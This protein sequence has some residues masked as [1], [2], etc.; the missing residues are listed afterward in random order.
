MDQVADKVDVLILGGGVAGTSLA[1]TLYEANR[2]FLLIDDGSI[3]S[4]SR[5]AAGLVTPITGKRLNETY[6]WSTAF[7]RSDA[8][9]RQVEERL[10]ET[11]W[12]RS[13]SVRMIDDTQS[14]EQIQERLKQFSEV[15]TTWLD[16]T[17]FDSTLVN[18]PRG[19]FM[20]QASRLDTKRYLEKSHR[21]FSVYGMYYRSWVDLDEDIFL[22]PNNVYFRPS[23]VSADYA[24]C[25]RG[26]ADQSHRLFNNARFNPVQGDILRI[27]LEQP[28]DNTTLHCNWW[29][30]PTQAEKTVGCLDL[31]RRPKV[32]DWLL[33]STYQW[34]PLDGVPSSAGRDSLLENLQQR[35]NVQ[36]EVIEH[37]A[38]VRPTTF[39]Q[40][41]FIGMHPEHPRLGMLNGLGAKGCYLAPWCAELLS[42]HLFEK[43]PIPKELI[44]NR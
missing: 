26:I 41:P 14:T 34:R 35:V 18:D 29:I 10:N 9:Y 22:Y 19:F 1:W 33:G 4:A 30:T 11:I 40:K 28:I 20:S 25:C 21:F 7:K 15:E 13:G 3:G 17:W 8:F 27:Q 31:M 23:Q 24:I 43:Q 32:S 38:A 37:N 12:Y 5:I 2:S 39:D 16:S 42:Q 44:W 6:Q 36:C